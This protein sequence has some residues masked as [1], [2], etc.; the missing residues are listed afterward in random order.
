MILPAEDADFETLDRL[1][2]VAGNPVVEGGVASEPV[3]RMLRDLARQI[4]PVCSPAAWW[5]VEEDEVAPPLGS[6]DRH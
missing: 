2:Q 3:M 5:I 6:P 1:G 4:R